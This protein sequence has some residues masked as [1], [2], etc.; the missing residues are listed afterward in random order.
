MNLANANT[1]NVSAYLAQ[2]KLSAFV[3][4]KLKEIVHRYDKDAEI[5]LFGSHARGDWDEESDWDF[6]ILSKY[7]EKSDI[8]EKIR[9]D[10]LDEIEHLVSEVVFILM[11]NK[12]V[13]EEDYSVTPLYYNIEE[14]GI[15]IA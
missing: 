2:D 1:K 10:I 5:I 6:L 12:K 8:K 13:W 7:P 9:K 15:V 14:E 11:H 3:I 4:N